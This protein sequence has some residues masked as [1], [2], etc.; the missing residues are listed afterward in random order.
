MRVR[1]VCEDGSDIDL[2]VDHQYP[3]DRDWPLDLGS[4]EPLRRL[5][6]Q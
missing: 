1:L 6:R 2:V 3:S 5:R 4:R